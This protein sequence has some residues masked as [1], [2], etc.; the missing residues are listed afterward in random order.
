MK[1][2]LAVALIWVLAVP[3]YAQGLSGKA[4]PGPPPPAPKTQQEIQAERAADQAY[5]N[6]LRNIP[7]QPPADPWGAARS[8]DKSKNIKATK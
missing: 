6:S 4:P 5:K 3:V 2:V 1:L 7:D 8:V